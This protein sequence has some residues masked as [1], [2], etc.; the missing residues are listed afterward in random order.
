MRIE[1]AAALLLVASL[2]TGPAAHAQNQAPK[3]PAPAPSPAP[4]PAKAPKKV[5]P[6]A[7]PP[8]PALAPPPAPPAPPAKKAEDE[9]IIEQL[10]LFML[11][12]MMKDYEILRETER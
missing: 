10:E 5:A 7:V 2:L 11:M 12:E 4:A 1:P 6:K 3:P 9:A 8:K